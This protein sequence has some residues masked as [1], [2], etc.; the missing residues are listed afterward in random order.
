MVITPTA[1]Y[2]ETPEN[3]NCYCYI[4]SNR[5]KKLQLTERKI[6]HAA[7]T[8]WWC[9]KRLSSRAYDVSSSCVGRRSTRSDDVI[10]QLRQVIEYRLYLAAG[11]LLTHQRQHTTTTTTTTTTVLRLPLCAS[12]T[13]SERELTFTFTFAI[14]CRPSV[15]RL[16]VTLNCN[17]RAP[18]SAGWN[19]RLCFYA[20]WYLGHTLTSTGNFTE[21]VSGEPFRQGFKR[22]R[23]S[24]M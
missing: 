1:S 14:C 12:T 10:G 13:I 21:I 7:L 23:G 2:W 15:C 9:N 20:I 18:Y 3:S 19:F 11:S 17:A 16:P 5:R 8:M 24:Q 6:S 4:V 22:K